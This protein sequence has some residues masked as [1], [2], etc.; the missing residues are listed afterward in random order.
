[1][2][3][4]INNVFLKKKFNAFIISAANKYILLSGLTAWLGLC[5]NRYMSTSANYDIYNG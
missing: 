4:E 3:T 2:R 1:M 5:I